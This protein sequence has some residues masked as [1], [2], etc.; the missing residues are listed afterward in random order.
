MSLTPGHR[1][2][3][4]DV[5]PMAGGGLSGFW[6]RLSPRRP[7]V[8]GN[9]ERRVAALNRRSLSQA[10]KDWVSMATCCDLHSPQGL[11]FYKALSGHEGL[12]LQR[13]GVWPWEPAVLWGRPQWDRHARVGV[14]TGWGSR[15]QHSSWDSGR[16]RAAGEGDWSQRVRAAGEEG[17]GGASAAGEGLGL[18]E[19]AG[20]SRQ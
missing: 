10:S 1:A 6:Q 13:H 9:V 15:G 5:R 16:H 3:W 20:K 7:A 17:L 4:A 11:S 2:R 12:T 8:P 18:R 19:K 14:R